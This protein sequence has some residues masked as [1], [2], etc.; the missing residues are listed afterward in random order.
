MRTEHLCLLRCPKCGFEL[1]LHAD[2]T[3][4]GRVR[5]GSLNCTGCLS[6]YLIRNYIP[7]LLQSENNYA[8][9]F[10]Y[11]WNK[12]YRTQY[13]AESGLPISEKR[14][15]DETGWSRNLEG[16]IILEAGCGSGRFTEQAASTG[17]MVV[18]FDYSDAVEA[19]LRSNGHK[20]NVLIVQADIYSSPF[21]RSFFD[22]V[23]CIGVL[24]HTPFPEAAFYSLVS[25]LKPHGHLVVDVYEKLPGWKK[26]FETKYWVRPITRRIRN[27]T[28]Y[29]FCNL[30]VN[31]LWP[32]CKLSYKITGRRTLSWLLLIADYRGVYPLSEKQLKQWSILDTFDMLAP[33]YDYPQNIE[34]VTHWF[35]KAGLVEIDV[36]RGY[37]GI[38]GSGYLPESTKPIQ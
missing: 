22:K 28:L 33:E 23:F 38:Q 15:F 36:K 21:P 24:Q 6:S 25:M 13:D 26:Y 37:N 31:C 10:G 29:R 20:Q 30:W 16:N 5:T 1:K 35:Q 27:E 18:S 9:D 19:N 8:D 11:E 34:S 17:A 14:F 2:D 3:K 12:H 4:E 32:L 7:R